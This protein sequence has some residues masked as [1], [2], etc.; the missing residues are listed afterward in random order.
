MRSECECQRHKD[1]IEIL[2]FG[3]TEFGPRV[4]AANHVGVM[5]PRTHSSPNLFRKMLRNTLQ[6]GLILVF[7]TCTNIAV[8]ERVRFAN[9][10]MILQK[11]LR[12]S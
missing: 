10:Q 6:D 11:T 7:G 1:R 5:Y 8:L 12:G 3:S 2:A 9:R 4:P